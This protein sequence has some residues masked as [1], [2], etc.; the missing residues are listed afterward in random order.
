M[1]KRKNLRGKE[2]YYHLEEMESILT[3]LLSK[4]ELDEEA[5]QLRDSFYHLFRLEIRKHI[6]GE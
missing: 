4:S 3:K 1:V 6:N 5:I 2:T